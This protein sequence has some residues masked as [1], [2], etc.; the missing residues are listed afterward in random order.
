M[1]QLDSSGAFVD[2]GNDYLISTPGLSGQVE[3]VEPTAPVSSG[4][5]SRGETLNDALSEVLQRSEF[6]EK[7]TL[8]LK[9]SLDQPRRSS[10]TVLSKEAVVLEVPNYGLD[11][12]HVVVSIST[13]GVVTWNFPQVARGPTQRKRFVIQQTRASQGTDSQD[14]GLL[15]FL[16]EQLLRVIVFPLIEGVVGDL[17]KRLAEEWE[18]ANRAYR[19]RAYGPDNYQVRDVPSLSPAELQNLAGGPALLLVH[20]TFGMAHI[21]FN[22]FKENLLGELHRRYQGRVFAFDHFTLSH[23]PKE[24]IRR[25]LELLPQGLELTLDVITH[26]RGGLVARALA[27]AVSL[28]G[29]ERIQVRKIIYGATPNHGTKLANPDHMVHFLDRISTMLNLIPPGPVQIVSDILEV[30]LVAVKL[31]GH[32]A[33]PALDGL[34]S[35]NPSGSF[36]TSLGPL[37]ASIQVYAIAANYQPKP[38]GGLWDLVHNAGIDLIFGEEAND[39]VVPTM[40]VYEGFQLADKLEFAPGDGVDHNMV[41]ANPVSFQ[42]LLQWLG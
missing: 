1:A 5:N 20:G 27:G 6:E 37:P 17:A 19:L 26:S 42:K 22:G 16:G 34:A 28:P 32:A 11:K 24:N 23:D 41:Y 30:I 4:R 3:F 36:I 25:F 38:L 9:P 29:L 21:T 10:T 18:G 13:D 12:G 40:G 31:I 35:M 15:A 33:L 7:R 39:L 14:R 8:R 2:L